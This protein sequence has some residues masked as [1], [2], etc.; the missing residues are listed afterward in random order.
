MKIV[1]AKFSAFCL[2]A[3]DDCI[4]QLLETCMMTALRNFYKHVKTVLQSME[5]TL[6]KKVK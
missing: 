4:M 2:D 3:T 1:I 5:I 6:E